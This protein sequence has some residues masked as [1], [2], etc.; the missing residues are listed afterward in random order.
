MRKKRIWAVFLLAGA[1]L[2]GGCHDS[3]QTAEPT[4]LYEQIGQPEAEVVKTFSLEGEGWTREEKTDSVEYYTENDGELCGYPAWM[5]LV[6]EEGTL[7]GVSCYAEIE[8]ATEQQMADAILELYNSWY[9]KLGEPGYP[10]TEY[11]GVEMDWTKFGTG[12]EL[13]GKLPVS[14]SLGT[15]SAWS[16]WGEFDETYPYMTVEITARCT[17][18]QTWDGR[19]YLE[20]KIDRDPRRSLMG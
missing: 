20:I 15:I 10:G 12:E 18:P 9:E 13:L 17:P 2:S 1:L 3:R 16:I 8:G 19:G 5:Q 14:E 4:A 11:P 7:S 6:F